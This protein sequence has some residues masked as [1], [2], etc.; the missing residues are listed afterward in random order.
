MCVQLENAWH[1]MEE[2]SVEIKNDRMFLFQ[3]IFHNFFHLEK[4]WHVC[5]IQV[6][7]CLEVFIFKDHQISIVKSVVHV[8]TQY[9]IV[10]VEKNL[11]VLIGQSLAY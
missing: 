11:L 3:K 8:C 9:K 6:S 4:H 5:L 7:N 2:K 10:I 1:V